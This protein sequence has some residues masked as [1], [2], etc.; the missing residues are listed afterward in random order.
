MGHLTKILKMMENPLPLMIDLL[1]VISQLF[2]P[3][4]P[5]PG[6]VLYRGGIFDE[7]VQLSCPRHQA[8]HLSRLRG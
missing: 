2:L 6:Q 4:K 8:S 1:D 3:Y 7:Y 5:P